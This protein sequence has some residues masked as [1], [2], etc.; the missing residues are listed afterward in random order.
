MGE[1]NLDARITSAREEIISLAGEFAETARRTVE[2]ALTRAM[3]R[4]VVR[5][6]DWFN[7]LDDRTATALRDT[8]QR[9]I[10][11]SSVTVGERLKDPDLWLSPSVMVDG[12]P[13]AQLDEPANRAW[14][15][16]LNA[17]DPLDPVLT[18]FGLQ[19]SDVPDRGGG[20]FGLQPK[21]AGELDPRGTLAALWARYRKLHE[22]YRR[23]L[24]E[25]RE[26]QG[27]DEARRRWNEPGS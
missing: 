24:R 20:H 27:E 22:A 14:I 23:A 15:A 12:Q 17:A 6:A 26:R 7:R 13:Q 11:R 9:T 5:Y 10:E 16:L 3:E 8:V 1:P 21:T 19:P 18:E 2:T 25:L 4:L